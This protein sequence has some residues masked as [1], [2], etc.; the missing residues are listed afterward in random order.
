LQVTNE[1]G[2]AVIDD[3]FLLLVNAS[4]EGVEFTVPPPLAG[5]TWSQVLDTEN[6]DAPFAKVIV[7]DKVIVGGRSM[8]VLSDETS[9]S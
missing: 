5:S 1:E 6:I 8:K 2:Q 3:S 4:H 9:K 7:D